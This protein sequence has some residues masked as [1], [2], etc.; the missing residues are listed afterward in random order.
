M[1]FSAAI[2]DSFLI[3]AGLLSSD[4]DS[5]LVE[6]LIFL[7]RRCLSADNRAVTVMRDVNK[8]I[9]FARIMVFRASKNLA[10]IHRHQF[11]CR[12]EGKSW[13]V[14]ADRGVKSH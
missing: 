13:E 5:S 12:D 6:C 8:H 3:E 1:E 9:N 4:D 10:E 11:V 14:M 7:D 2:C